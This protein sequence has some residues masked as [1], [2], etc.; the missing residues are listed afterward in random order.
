MK[1]KYLNL[2]LPLGLLL[3]AVFAAFVISGTGGDEDDPA[4]DIR[5]YKSVPEWINSKYLGHIIIGQV[6]SR[7]ASRISSRTDIPIETQKRIEQAGG[8]NGTIVTDYTFKIEQIIKGKGL[9]PGETIT[10]VQSGGTVDGRSSKFSKTFQPIEVGER[11]ILSLV[12]DERD[13]TVSDAAKKYTVL[14]NPEARYRIINGRV[15]LMPGDWQQIPSVREFQSLRALSESEF[16]DQAER[17]V[18]K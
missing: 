10:I 11:A 7:E 5:H 16:I 3:F 1:R 12:Y 17:L 18:I 13:P 9:S 6:I 14:L 4:A 8:I 15:E 2:L